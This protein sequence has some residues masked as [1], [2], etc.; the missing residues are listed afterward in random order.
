MSEA[1]ATRTPLFPVRRH[2]FRITV[3]ASPIRT[4]YYIDQGAR[5][6]PLQGLEV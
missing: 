2:V 3:L 1:K 5:I 4:S 6:R